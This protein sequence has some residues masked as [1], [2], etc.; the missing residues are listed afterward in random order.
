MA[1]EVKI[2]LDILDS[3][4]KVY[5]ESIETL[6]NA[7]NELSTTIEELRSQQWKSNGADAFFQN[8]DDTWKKE[9]KDHISY[10]KH[11]RDCLATAQSLYHE[12]YDAKM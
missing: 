3:V 2:N 5:D 12:K 4:K 10:L 1:K 9:L 11:L 7:L 6:E 8:Y